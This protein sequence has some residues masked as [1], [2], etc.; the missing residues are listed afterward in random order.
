[1]VFVDRS[2][3]GRFPLA[4][5]M[6]DLKRDALGTLTRAQR[7]HGDMVRFTTGIGGVRA[8]LL[9]TFSAEGVQQVLATQAANFCKDT[10]VYREVRDSF[11]NGLLT[12]LDEDHRRQRRLAQP[13]FTRRRVDSYAA[14]FAAEANALLEAW[15]RV[16]D[17]VVDVA[18]EMS[19]FTLTT[20]GNIL[21]GS[22]METIADVVNRSYRLVSSY[23]VRRGY[24]P[25]RFPRSW[26]T[27]GNRRAA[28]AQRELYGVCDALIAKRSATGAVG[29]DLLSMLTTAE[30]AEDGVLSPDEI[31]DQVLI[32][33]LA[34]QETTATSMAYALHV[35]ALH[36]DIQERAR[37]EVDHALGGRLPTAADLELLPY[38]AMVFNEAMRLYPAGPV[39]A[40]RALT[41]T[42][43]EGYPI[44]AGSDVLIAAWVTH[45]H[46]RYWDDP[47]RCDPLRFTAENEASRPRYAYF[48]FGGGPRACIGQ[49]FA[50]LNA[51]LPLAMIVRSYELTVVDR[52][53]PLDAGITLATMGPLRCQLTPRRTG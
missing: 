42:Q 1:M 11:G 43:I 50:K 20:V 29:E 6:F 12:S 16:P 5:S 41:D 14:A 35:L 49:H 44:P 28:A 7:E 24:S 47:L 48:P 33:L 2:A 39:T 3:S 9:C 15:R 27:P 26:P 45:R 40:R 37:E 25:V 4:G 30:N 13:L 31:R 17:G 10:I 18:K 52:D 23:T 53:V 46:P 32:F 36:P 22:D 51:L 38:L 8:E 19:T 34:G 21:F